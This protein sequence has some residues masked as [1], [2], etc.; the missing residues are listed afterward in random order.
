MGIDIHSLNL[1]RHATARHG[2]LRRTIS[3][4]RLGVQLGPRAAKQW[5]GTTT[6][7]YAEDMLI[8]KF[9]ATD[10]DSIDNS[11]YEGATIVGDMNQPIPNR[12]VGLY[13]TVLDFGCTEHIFDVAQSMRNITALC[14]Q[15]GM[16]LHAVP[17]NGFC[18]HGFYQFSPE[19]FF[20][21]YSL[22]NGYSDTEVYLADL[23]DTKH[24]YRVS[25]PTGGRRINVRSSDEMYVLVVTRR[26]AVVSG[27][28]Q[29]SDYV[30]AWADRH[31]VAIPPHRPGRFAGVREFL[32]I[33]RFATKLSLRVD[34]LLSSDKART[35]NH[36]PHCTRTTAPP[37][38]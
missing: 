28:V 8:R 23:L 38:L 25:P 19:L 33:N 35:L 17:S 20:S 11:D 16:V 24:W 12:L 30:Y 36:N 27:D 34:A 10:V 31:T 37:S 2:N 22:R 1:L 4:G 26:V 6:G 3:L 29:Q 13:D 9:G 32:T 15:G 5:A 14:K 18:G 7:A 21:L